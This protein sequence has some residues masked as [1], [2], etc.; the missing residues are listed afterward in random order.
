MGIL[1]EKNSEQMNFFAHSQDKQ[2]RGLGNRQLYFNM[3]QS[4]DPI[5]K[6]KKEGKKQIEL[7]SPA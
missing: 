1:K 7:T 5:I 6:K 2:G 3:K 4:P